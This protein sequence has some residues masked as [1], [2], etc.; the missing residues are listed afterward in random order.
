MERKEFCPRRKVAPPSAEGREGERPG[1]QV[2]SVS[3]GKRCGWLLR[4]RRKARPVLR[5]APR[6]RKLRESDCRRFLGLGEAA[7]GGMLEGFR[8]R[9]G[10]GRRCKS[11]PRCRGKLRR[12]AGRSPGAGG[13]AGWR[14]GWWRRSRGRWPADLQEVLWGVAGWRYATRPVARQ[15]LPDGPSKAVRTPRAANRGSARSRAES[16]RWVE[17][18]SAER[19]GWGSGFR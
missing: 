5:D 2:A 1:A 9:G 19:R 4:R 18:D 17:R 15:R 6:R 12:N 7:E 8:R 11:F 14:G 10:I 13:G 3:C 16:R